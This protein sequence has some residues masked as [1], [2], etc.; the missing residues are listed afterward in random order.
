[1]LSDSLRRLLAHPLT[2]GLQLDDPATVELRRQIIASKPFLQAIYDQWYR[3]LAEHLPT[4]D[5]KVVELGSGPGYC[6]RFIP[7]L[8][9]SET[10]L[11][12]GVRL[13]A[14][15]QRLPFREASLRAIVCTDVLHHVPDV[16]RFFAEASRSLLPGGKILMIEPWVSPW[17][18]L[19][20]ARFHHEPFHPEAAEWS[21]DPSGANIALPWIVF[22]RD[23]RRFETEFPGLLIDI[24]KPLMPFRYLLSGGVTLRALAPAFTHPLW[25]RLEDLLEPQMAKLAMFAFISVRKH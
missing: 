6:E 19:V 1:L 2:A 17:S 24:I 4:L 5:G 10:F 13:V 3:L 23:R 15:A 9:T 20:F 7:D 21:L 12:R 8:I 25:R 22:V 18:R 16:R 14:D 11:C